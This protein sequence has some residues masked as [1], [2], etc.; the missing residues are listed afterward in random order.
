MIRFVHLLAVLS[1]AGCSHKASI[2]VRDLG[3][4]YVTEYHPSASPGFDLRSGWRRVCDVCRGDRCER[5]NVAPST[6]P[7]PGAPR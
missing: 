5:V 4:D 6:S 3:V 7:C 1:L 2:V